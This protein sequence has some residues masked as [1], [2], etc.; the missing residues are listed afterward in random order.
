MKTIIQKT[1]TER[2]LYMFCNI[3]VAS[4]FMFILATK[5][6]YSYISFSLSIIAI[7]FLISQIKNKYFTHI[8]LIPEEKNILIISLFYVLTFVTHLIIGDD[9]LR[10]IDNPV[11]LILLL[12]IIYLLI[13][14]KL[15]IDIVLFSIPIGSLVAGLSA[16]TQRFFLKIEL[17]YGDFMSIQ[18]GG[19]SMSLG[20]FSIAIAMYYIKNKKY[21]LPLFYSTCGLLG[22]FASVLASARG[23]ILAL[24][25]LLFIV[26]ICFLRY[27]GS[28]KIILLCLIFVG[29]IT[30]TVNSPHSRVHHQY[31]TTVKDLSN[32]ITKGER[33]SSIGARIDMWYSAILAFKEKPILGWG[34]EGYLTLK[35]QQ[36]KNK[37]IVKNTIKYND[38]HN[39]Y[40]DALAKRGI[41]GLLGLLLIFISP[42][43]YFCKR[44]RKKDSEINIFSL[45]AV[46]HITATMIY[47]L[48]QSF[49]NHN[50]GSVFYFL[51]LVIM[52]S[53][54]RKQEE[55]EA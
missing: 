15:N 6:T 22:M 38:A 36:L 3:L 24:P 25:V 53:L 20:V 34:K 18:A 27:L 43:I 55:S 45:L 42:L 50:S 49:L 4:F 44:I 2:N 40:L 48:T 26:A 21:L 30:Y 41:V 54:V 5:K 9:R 51:T 14:S 37:L 17:V 16:I 19:I 32:V 23:A 52:Y 35:E 31:Q 8:K 13:K 12:P 39:Q 7:I 1:L 33:S 29:I 46:L 10:E 47:S 28:K 11:R